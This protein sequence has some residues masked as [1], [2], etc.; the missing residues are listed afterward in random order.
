MRQFFGA[1][2]PL[3]F[4]LGLATSS[5]CS[6]SAASIEHRQGMSMEAGEPSAEA[7]VH[8]RKARVMDPGNPLFAFDLFKALLRRN[9]NLEAI[10]YG[11]GIIET[12]PDSSF[13]RETRARLVGAYQAHSQKMSGFSRWEEALES[14]EAALVID[15]SAA[16][17]PGLPERLTQAYIHLTGL[18]VR[19]RQYQPA[20]E[21]FERLAALKGRP[22]ADTGR[23]EGIL[24]G[25]GLGR[26]MPECY[27][28]AARRWKNLG[29]PEKTLEILNRFE[30]IMPSS[31]MPPEG[32]RLRLEAQTMMSGEAPGRSSGTQSRQ[33][34]GGSASPSEVDPH[35]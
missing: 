20:V 5:R 23:L 18:Y 7:M 26:Q 8:L 15:P 13:A 35:D 33:D 27:V 4:G 25:Q 29:H 16:S 9:R 19:S 32:H 31:L 2:T 28:R 34:A 17:A 30:S 12:F 10:H 6:G 24:S 1:F 22:G 21:T 3:I 14:L 11:K